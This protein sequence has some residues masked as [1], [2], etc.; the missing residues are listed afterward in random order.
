VKEGRVA[1]QRILITAAA[2]AAALMLYNVAREDDDPLGNSQRVSI[3]RSVL[4]EAGFA[5][6]SPVE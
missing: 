5:I 4:Y 1:F 6:D 3:P 2:A